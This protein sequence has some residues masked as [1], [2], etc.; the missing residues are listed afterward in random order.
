MGKM[1]YNRAVDKNNAAN[2]IDPFNDESGLYDK[3]SA[4]SKNL[5][6]QSIEYLVKSVNFYD[7]L[8]D[9]NRK[10]ALRAN[11]G[12]SLTALANAYARVDMLNEAEAAKARLQQLAN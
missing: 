2:A 11:L 5:F 3:L 8:T 12:N 1:I 9:E 7:A 4:E 6:R 10:G